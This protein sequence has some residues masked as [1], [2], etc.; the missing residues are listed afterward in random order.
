[1]EKFWSRLCS[2][3]RKCGQKKCDMET[4]LGLRCDAVLFKHHIDCML[5]LP[6]NIIS[7]MLRGSVSEGGIQLRSYAYVNTP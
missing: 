6:V 5:R 1:M 7:Q 4:L 3:L 2:Q